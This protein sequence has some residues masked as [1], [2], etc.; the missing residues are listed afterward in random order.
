MKH[1]GESLSQTSSIRKMNKVT[2]A[3]PDEKSE[4]IE[5]KCYEKRQQ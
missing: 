5:Y 3:E 1:Y 4:G 2:I